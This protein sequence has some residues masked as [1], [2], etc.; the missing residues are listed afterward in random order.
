MP[1]TTLPR[2]FVFVFLCILIGGIA[3]AVE[4]LAETKK[5]E[6]ALVTV[7]VATMREKPSYAAEMAT[8]CLLGMPLRI[9]ERQKNWIC[10]D[11]PEA[12]RCWVQRESVV[13]MSREEL[14]RWIAAPKLIFLDSYGFCFSEPDAKSP[15]V[16][17]LAAGCV[18][19]H[20]GDEG[21]YHK[22]RFPD[23]RTAFVRKES[24]EDFEQWA[25]K[26]RPTGES[27]VETAREFMGVPYLWGGTSSKMLDCSG[28]TKLC[29]FLN[30][31]II[32]RNASQQAKVGQPI[33]ISNGFDRLEKGDLIFFGTKNGN[34]TKI[35]HV[36]LYVEN[37]DFIHEAGR[38]RFGSLNPESRWFDK[39]LAERQVHAS[40]LHIRIGT[41]KISS[42]KEHPFYQ[43]DNRK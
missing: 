16:A 41:E 37:G 11:T 12:Y 27:L 2:F 17:D 21:D 31:V 23:G 35:T 1:E 7:S 38:V 29:F 8:Q 30:G 28:L 14:D 22:I 13:V 9:V 6:F 42:I 26:T 36:G 3:G 15:K 5:D 10:I 40:R 43:I 4:S 19:R 39:N 33:D 32:P 20:E 18:F 24:C 25:E 34:E